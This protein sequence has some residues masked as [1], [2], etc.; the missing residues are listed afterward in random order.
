MID[1]TIDMCEEAIKCVNT[2]GTTRAFC[3]RAPRATPAA[4]GN[5][6]SAC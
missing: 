5:A 3:Y 4:F 1:A 2:L 6:G